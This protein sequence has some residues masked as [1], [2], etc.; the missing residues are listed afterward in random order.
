MDLLSIKSI[1][2][3]GNPVIDVCSILQYGSENLYSELAEVQA[4]MYVFAR[5]KRDESSSI[6][7][8]TFKC[9]YI[10]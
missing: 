9:K 7:I 5:E 10:I 4:M 1:P 6:V 8:E 3:Y 2:W